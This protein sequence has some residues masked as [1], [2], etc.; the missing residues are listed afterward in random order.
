MQFSFIFLAFATLINADRSVGARV[1]ATAYEDF[2]ERHN[3]AQAVDTLTYAERLRLFMQRSDAVRA[4]NAA[5]AA[6]T[7]S[8]RATVNKFADYTDAEF[9]MLLGHRPSRRGQ[10]TPIGQ[11]SSSFIQSQPAGNDDM[12]ATSVDWTQSLN[13]TA[14]SVKDQGAC[15]SCWAVAAVGALE[16]HQQ[17]ASKTQGDIEPLSYEELVDCVA[18]PNECGGQGGC[19]GA[20]AELAFDHVQKSGL[21]FQ[22]D[23]K[24]YQHGGDGNCKAHGT[25]YISTSG[26]QRLPTN[27]QQPLLQALTKGPVVL[28]VAANQWSMY[29]S[30]V[31][32]GCDRNAI[33]NHAVLGVGY[34]EDKALGKK[35][36][37]IRN[38]WGPEWGE[39]GHI[40]MN[41]FDTDKG[42]AG[43][44]GM[45]AK[46]Q[47]GVG[48]KGETKAIEVCG[49]C[50]VLS[51]SCYPTDVRLVE[52]HGGN[53]L[54]QRHN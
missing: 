18:N 34:G 1:G 20:T 29:S 40:R 36:F 24:G 49:E 44:C 11:A 46:P 45:D 48:C 12:I 10:T 17:L 53:S 21:G 42:E 16:A 47:D 19:K 28:S 38:S 39:S 32:H 14:T 13:H 4:Q 33:V 27:E 22:V 30:G 15:G 25:K 43:N 9:Q 35:Y 41:R 3:R 54:V 37:L 50:G 7:S 52:G 2:R 23:Y 6:G 26:F 31:F 5:F 8:W 51:D